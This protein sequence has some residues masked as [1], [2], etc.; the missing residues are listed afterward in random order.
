MDCQMPVM[1]G[2]DATVA[3][4]EKEQFKA[5]PVIAMTANV[6]SGDRDKVLE[7]GMNDLIGKPI[8]VGD[9]FK[10][11]AKWITPSEPLQVA[12]QS[13]ATEPEIKEAALG[14]LPGID[15]RIGL[16]TTQ[17]NLKLYRKLLL[18]FRAS[19][20]DFEKQFRIAQHDSDPDAA[21]RCAHTVKGVAGNIAAKAVQE[22][23][24]ALETACMEDNKEPHEIDVLLE[25]VCSALAPVIAGL[26]AIDQPAAETSERRE[27]DLAT[28][29]PLLAQLREL[30]EDDD[31][32]AQDVYEEL[33]SLLA[34]TVHANRFKRL[35]D[36]L[37]SYDFEEARRMLGEIDRNLADS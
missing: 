15:I 1:N 37:G 9:M 4:R 7:A 13:E 21:T 31:T 32:D 26:D 28:A 14:E 36:S 12:Q 11:M 23:A 33:E 25:Q 16:A 29:K 10:T 6:M 3:I 19:Q 18:K 27:F 20:C 17:N 34:G 2:Y 24:Q 8:N 5:L 30:L 35:G 22:A